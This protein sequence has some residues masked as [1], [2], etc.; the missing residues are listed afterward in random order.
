MYLDSRKP[1][2][3]L[4]PRARWF[5]FPLL[6]LGVLIVAVA[7][8]LPAV[9]AV[10]AAR[11]PRVTTVL[12]LELAGTGG[13]I[14][15]IVLVSA[16]FAGLHTAHTIQTDTYQLI[17][18]THV[19]RL[20][21]VRYHVA[22]VLQRLRF[23]L[24]FGAALAPAFVVAVMHWSVLNAMP[25][26]PGSPILRRWLRLPAPRSALVPWRLETIGF[27][28]EFGGWVLGLW[29]I[30]LLAIVLSIGLTLRWRR[31]AP[32]G[33]AGALIALL[34]AAA[35]IAPIL[36]LPLE[37]WEDTPRA[38]LTLALAFAPYLAA[39]AAMRLV[40]PWA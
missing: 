21:L 2:S 31:A 11:T 25:M 33:V 22:L 18:L 32:A 5:T 28:P 36:L 3:R 19:P 29:G 23:L 26:Y 34:L 24:A 4:V 16:L 15:L 37:R 13:V 9:N 1:L 27:A 17:R 14:L 6:A 30:V 12:L 10:M 38:L 40:R 39:L 7:V 8:L 35:L 20:A